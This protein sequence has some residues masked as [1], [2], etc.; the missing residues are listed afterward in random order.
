ME[1]WR[2]PHPHKDRP[3]PSIIAGV[4][5]VHTNEKGKYATAVYYVRHAWA[6][7]VEKLGEFVEGLFP[8][9]WGQNVSAWGLGVE[10]GAAAYWV[11]VSNRKQTTRTDIKRKLDRR[12]LG[13]QVEAVC[14]VPYTG[15][16]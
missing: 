12:D 5:S 9:S 13:A 10:D 8:Q 7:S 4:R 3:S 11:L 2:G 15:E 14:A 16:A 6:G 1:L